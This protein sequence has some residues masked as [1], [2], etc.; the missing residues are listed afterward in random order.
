MKEMR[1]KELRHL[2]RAELLEL[3]L[4]QIRENERLQEKL[5]E[6]EAKL[7]DRKL[8]VQQAGDLAHAVLVVNGVVEAAQ[9][10]AQQYLDNIAAMEA[11]TREKCE[12]IVSRAREEAVLLQCGVK[13][14][15]AGEDA[16]DSLDKLLREIYESL[17]LEYDK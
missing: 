6:T 17:G 10:A 5:K 7:A 15:P 2:S 16:G 1:E 3:L 13:K 4:A 9:Q 11:E 8:Q 14:E 12:Q